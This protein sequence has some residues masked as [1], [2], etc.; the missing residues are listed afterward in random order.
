MTLAKQ[1]ED[2]RRRRGDQS[3]RQIVDAMLALVREGE[4]SP[5]AAQVAERAGVGLRTVFRHF[6]EMEVLYREMAEAI[7]EKVLP[8]MK[9]PYASDGWRDRLM[10]MV[11]RR[12]DIHEEIM[13]L[14]IAGSI[15]RFRSQFLMEDYRNHLRMER[16]ALEGVLPEQVRKDQTLFRAIEMTTSFQ[17]WRRLR[18]DQ[19]LSVADARKVVVRLLEGVLGG[20]K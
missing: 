7:A 4:M 15:L 12:V 20:V 3:R 11:E 6:E 9:R 8:L 19:D 18:Q 16:K 1:S 5:S 13:P 14:K 17:A 10:E 2:G